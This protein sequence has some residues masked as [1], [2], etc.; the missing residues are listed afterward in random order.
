[1]LLAGE[2]E[3]PFSFDR[4]AMGLYRVKELFSTV[5]GRRVEENETEELGG[6]RVLSVDGSPVEERWECRPDS[7]PSARISDPMFTNGGITR[8]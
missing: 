8:L 7:K 5:H 3:R 4:A 1:M 2:P 6:G